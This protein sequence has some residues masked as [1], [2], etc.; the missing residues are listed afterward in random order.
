VHNKILTLIPAQ[1]TISVVIGR[2]VDLPT[3]RLIY[4]NGEEEV[5]TDKVTWKSSTANLLVKSTSMK[6]LLAANATLTGT[7]L[8]K[9]VK[10][11]VTVEEEFTSFAI[12]PAKVSVTLNRTQTVKVVGTTKS[13]KKVTLSSRVDWKASNE[14][15]VTI[16]GSTV[17]GLTEGSGT[18]TASVQGK[19]LEIPYVVTAKLTKLTASQTSFKAVAGNQLSVSVTALYENGKSANVTSQATWTTSKPSVATVTNGQI[20]VK[21]KGSATIKGT[22]G[23][24]SVTIRV[25]VK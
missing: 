11:K 13:G 22:F 1:D 4:E 14:E 21:A 12:T 3:V 5:I 25:S 16:K 9:T 15:H 19:P 8:N 2:E 10:V 17:R 23:G 24:K 18:L 7:Y 6:G 20:S